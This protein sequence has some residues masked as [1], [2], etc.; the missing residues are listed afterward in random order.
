M[1]RWLLDHGF[2]EV[3]S[4]SSHRKFTRAGQGAVTVAGHGP[5]D[6]TKKQV[7]MLLRALSAMGFDGAATRTELQTGRWSRDAQRPPQAG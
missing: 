3:R 6:I 7:G 5:T 4:R 1:V 2:T